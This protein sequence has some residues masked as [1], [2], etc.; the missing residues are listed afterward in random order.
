MRFYCNNKW[1]TITTLKFLGVQGRAKNMR[2]N[3]VGQSVGRL[4]SHTHTQPHKLQPQK[5]V[6]QHTKLVQEIHYKSFLL[7]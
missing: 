4:V 7:T 1:H 3:T 6:K 2:K 5:D